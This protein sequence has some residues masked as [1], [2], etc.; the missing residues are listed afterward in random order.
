MLIAK[1]AKSMIRHNT[2]RSKDFTGAPFVSI[3]QHF[4]GGH[5]NFP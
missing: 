1:T 2:F 5:R 3:E 4:P